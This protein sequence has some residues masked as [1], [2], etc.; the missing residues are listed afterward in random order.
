VDLNSDGIPDIASGSYSPG[1]VYWFQGTG[2]GYLPSREIP[3]E[4]SSFDRHA[5]AATFYDWDGDGD[6][7]MLVGN[8]HGQVG[9][10][11][12]RGTRTAFRFG[13]RTALRLSDRSFEAPSGDAQPY[14]VD[15]DADGLLDLLV[16][17]GDGSVM[18]FPGEGRSNEGIPV[19]GAGRILI[20][21]GRLGVRIK[22]FPHDWNEDGHLDLLVG[23]RKRPEGGY[24]YVF[25]RQP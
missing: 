25:L 3:E 10:A 14:P 9:W 7:D 6:L 2:R 20:P 15:W 13:P 12:N 17:C 4:G 18:F 8:I 21:A 24:L 23:D 19:F 5:T 1:A 16:A 22:V 11:E